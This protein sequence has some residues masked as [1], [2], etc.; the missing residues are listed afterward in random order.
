MNFQRKSRLINILGACSKC[1]RIPQ[2][3]RP[4]PENSLVR[5]SDFCKW[6]REALTAERPGGGVGWGG[7]G[8]SAVSPKV[9]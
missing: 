2:F 9:L 8:K 6:Q 3:P 1:R 5:I 4:S 7:G